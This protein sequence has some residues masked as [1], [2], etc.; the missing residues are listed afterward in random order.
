MIFSY[1]LILT[2]YV[3]SFGCIITKQVAEILLVYVD[4][5]IL[6]IFLILIIFFPK[7]IKI[8]IKCLTVVKK[9]FPY[10]LFLFD[11]H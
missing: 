4:G 1:A 6:K 8:R 5:N 10:L 7:M 3:K 11:K 2:R 9:A